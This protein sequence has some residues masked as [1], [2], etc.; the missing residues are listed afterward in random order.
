M[1]PSPVL[2]LQLFVVRVQGRPVV[3]PSVSLVPWVVTLSR[4]ERQGAGW[5]SDWLAVV[6]LIYGTRTSS[7]E[8]RRWFLLLLRPSR[9]I[10]YGEVEFAEEKSQNSLPSNLLTSRVNCGHLSMFFP[11]AELLEL[12]RREIITAETNMRIPSCRCCCCSSQPIS[13]GSAAPLKTDSFDLL[14]RFHTFG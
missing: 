3:G 11:P 9:M 12:E 10:F 8:R 6:G 1:F 5:L 2:L 4:S 14:I 13:T 7:G